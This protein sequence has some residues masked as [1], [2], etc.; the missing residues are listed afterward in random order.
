[1]CGEWALDQTTTLVIKKACPICCNKLAIRPKCVRSMSGKQLRLGYAVQSFIGNRTSRKENED[2]A[3]KHI[4]TMN[5]SKATMRLRTLRSV[6]APVPVKGSR[7]HVTK[8]NGRW[9]GQTCKFQHPRGGPDS[10]PATSGVRIRITEVV[11]DQF[12]YDRRALVDTQTNAVIRP[13]Y[14]EPWHEL[15]FPKRATQKPGQLKLAR[16]GDCPHGHDTIWLQTMTAET[17]NEIDVGWVR[18]VNKVGKTGSRL[19]RTRLRCVV[20]RDG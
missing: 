4:K 19:A 14:A 13:H 12:P 10:T 8:D 17:E 15:V 9:R 2:M 20:G 16:W 3:T 11:R 5:K 1:M 18:L 7:A 6:G